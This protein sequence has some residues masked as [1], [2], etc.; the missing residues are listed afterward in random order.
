MCRETNKE[1]QPATVASCRD[2]VQE[3]GIQ[4]TLSIDTYEI[5]LS[6]EKYVK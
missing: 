4:C 3:G 1:R 2:N 6:V 5:Q